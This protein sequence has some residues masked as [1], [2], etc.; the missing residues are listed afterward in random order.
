M[1]QTGLDG[2]VGKSSLLTAFDELFSINE[3]YNIICAS[4]PKELL[5]SVIAGDGYIYGRFIY[6]I[7][8]LTGFLPYKLFGLDGLVFSIRFT[9]ALALLLGFHILIQKFIINKGIQTLALLTLLVFPFTIYFMGMPK[10]ESFQILL[11]AL[12]IKYQ[13]KPWS[14][15]FLGFAL[16]SKISIVFGLLFFAILEL[17][18][19]IKR[20]QPFTKLLKKALYFSAALVFTV[21]ALPLSLI[22]PYFKQG[23]LQIVSTTSKP[24]DDPNINFVDWIELMFTQ[25]F[26]LPLALH[27]IFSALLLVATIYVF[28]KQPINRKYIIFGLL[29]ILPIM[30]LTKRL[31]GHYLYLGFI[32]IIPIIFCGLEK[33]ESRKIKI[34]CAGIAAFFIVCNLFPSSQLYNLIIQRNRTIQ[35]LNVKKNT[36]LAIENAKAMSKKK[37]GVHLELYYEYKWQLD[38]KDT[39]KT[40]IYS[41]APNETIPELDFY[42]EHLDAEVKLKDNVFKKSGVLNGVKYYYD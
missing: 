13:D 33:I 7:D 38:Q 32:L 36:N 26:G 14:Y 40:I 34:A 35:F 16:G 2:Y 1:S 25:F 3:T 19:L 9:H 42:I 21:P 15:L 18:S 8:A 6:V 41:I 23:L 11:L 4:N 20:E 29:V 10:P 27:I 5:L 31:W 12:F 37:I 17:K 24:Y 39:S 22:N 28:I 30:L